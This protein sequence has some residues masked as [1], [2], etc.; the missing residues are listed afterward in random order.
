MFRLRL[1]SAIFGLIV[2]FGLN[3]LPACAGEDLIKQGIAEYN[4]GD[5]GNA[6]GHL[7]AALS[8]D[9]NNPVLHYYLGNS[10]V[11]LKQK[12]GAI[13]EFRIAYALQPDA[14]VGQY[15]KD[16]LALLG[17]SVVEGGGASIAEHAAKE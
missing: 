7:G 8:T 13:R 1:S 3:G 4:A 12:D 6:A 15:S 17:A 2:A 16:A 5:F 11:R 9:F 10:Y 14:Q